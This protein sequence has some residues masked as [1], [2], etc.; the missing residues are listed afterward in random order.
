M[1]DTQGTW[2]DLAVDSYLRD[3]TGTVWRVCAIDRTA[4][5]TEQTGHLRCKNR[6]GEWLTITPKPK[7]A[8][9]TI[10]V[11]TDADLVPL[12]RDKLG[13][14]PL[15]QQDHDAMP[16]TLVHCDPWEHLRALK[17]PLEDFRSH[18]M[19]AHDMHA[20]DLNTYVKLQDAH[21]A[22]HDPSRPHVGSPVNHTHDRRI[23]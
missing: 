15:Y 21:A 3:R 13:A 2:G 17:V 11:P 23:S 1:R 9:V 7:A 5:N 16:G 18:L 6:Q 19:L 14:I 10:L 12:L 8:P 20:A 22:A 4:E